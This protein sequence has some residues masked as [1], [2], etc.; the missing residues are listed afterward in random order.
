[1]HAR[2]F[3]PVPG[4]PTNNTCSIASPRF[5][6][7]AMAISRTSLI[8]VWPTNSCRRSGGRT[9][10]GPFG[11]NCD[12]TILACISHFVLQLRCIEETLAGARRSATAT[13]F[14]VEGRLGEVL[15]NNCG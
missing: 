4:G 13:V 6:E 15:D 3:L 12:D 5:F 8:R 1:M 10:S 11:D 2:V 9:M 7:A 14:P